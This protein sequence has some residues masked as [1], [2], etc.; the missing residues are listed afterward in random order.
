MQE[1]SKKT[2]L[3]TGAFGQDGR[4]LK[5]LLIEKNYNIIE[6][7]S[8]K[9]LYNDLEIK[10]CNILIEEDIKEILTNY[11]INEIYYFAAKVL[12][13]EERKIDE[14]LSDSFDE[15]FNINVRGYH[16]FLKNICKNTKI[17]YPGSSYMFESSDDF[18]TEDSKIRPLSLYAIN[19]TNAYFL[20]KYYKE[21]FNYFISVGFLFNHESLYRSNAYISQKIIKQAKEIKLGKREKFNV[22]NE[23]QKVDWGHAQEYVKAI[24]LIM[25]ND[26]A[27]DFIISSGELNSVKDF[28]K[29]VCQKM[30]IHYHDQIIISENNNKSLPYYFG[31][32]S[33]IIKTLG[34]KP[35]KK[36]VDI[37]SDMIV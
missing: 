31:N 20:S 34:W 27:D 37:I 10:H 35:R 9:S 33:K 14:N 17:F 11:S 21:K 25:Q 22:F 12:S 2:A 13:T 26:R 24:Y 32:N 16:F 7:G 1:S 18:I 15:N 19:K 6:I 4:F 5:K 28:I 30:N 29:I 36:L 23:N 8:K 3:I